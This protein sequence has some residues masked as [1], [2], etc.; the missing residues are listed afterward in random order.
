M[1]HSQH[2]HSGGHKPADHSG[3][4]Q[5]M[6]EDFRNRFFTA[7]VLTIPVLLLSPTVQQWLNYTLDLPYA[8]YLLFALASVISVYAAWPFYTGAFGETKARKP[9]MMTLVALAV[10]AGYLFSAA[11]T[12]I[13]RGETDFYWEIATLVTVLLLGH[14]L[15]MKAVLGTG[16]ALTELVKLI[17]P[18]ANLITGS[19]VKVVETS[20]LKIGDK[21][22]I[23]PGEKAPV[24]GIITEGQSSLNEAMLTGESNPVTKKTGNKIF[25]GTINIDGSLTV[26]ITKVGSATALAQIMKLVS[27]AQNTKPRAQRLADA[28]ASWLTLTAI[29]AGLATLLVWTLVLSQSFVFAL[30]LSITVV[31]I[32]C[33]HALGLAIPTVT[34]ITTQL[35]AKNGILIKNMDALET[36]EKIDYIV[37]DKTGTLTK[38]E[39]AVTDISIP[40]PKSKTGPFVPLTPDYDEEKILG[41]SLSLSEKSSHPIS[42]AIASHAAGRNI[43]PLAISDFKNIPGMG[44]KGTYQHLRVLL[45]NINLLKEYK[46]QTSQAEIAADILAREGKTI[47]FLAVGEE[48]KGIVALSDQLRPEAREAVLKLKEMGIG[49]AMLTGDNEATAAYVA[50]QLKL[51]AFFA[52]VAPGGKAEKIK[53]LQD[54]NNKVLMV[55][56]GINDAPALTQAN[57]GAA[58]G[59]GTDVAVESAQIILV[60]NN[61]L[62]IVKL[63]SLSRKTKAK[64]VQNLFWATAYNILAIPLAAGVLYPYGI[65][66][67]PEW[68][69]LAMTASSVIVVANAL[70]LKRFTV[71]A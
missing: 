25:G 17:P 20:S 34:T 9:G 11:T 37:F 16:N 23:K 40:D 56:D 2:Q 30:T 48:I 45:G 61:P 47:S 63:I 12:F 46:L 65:L 5:M 6:A 21:I 3:H 38:G 24:D 58:I 22:L 28:A 64:M 33:P 42:K 36:A 10:A 54:G 66:L 53:E 60:K 44:V 50:R 26:E 8:G 1:N 49:V 67:R 71:S 52:N 43:S 57:I 62:D 15:E 7:A 13:W 27:E 59:A 35:A 69:A 68:G 39:F 32:T 4:H 14:W 29:V 55:G 41:L 31:V 70:T 18:K 51:D 19:G